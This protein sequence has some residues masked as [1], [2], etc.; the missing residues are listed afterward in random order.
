MRCRWT[1]TS[2]WS[3]QK[4]FLVLQSIL[5]VTLRLYCRAAM[6]WIL[7]KHSTRIPLV[8]HQLC[9][10][11]CILMKFLNHVNLSFHAMFDCGS[12]SSFQEINSFPW[13]QMLVMSK[14]CTFHKKEYLLLSCVASFEDW[15]GIFRTQTFT[16]CKNGPDFND[17]SDSL[18]V[19]Q[20]ISSSATMNLTVCR[21]KKQGNCSLS[22]LSVLTSLDS[23]DFNSW[24]DHF[25]SA[26]HSE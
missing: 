9:P 15:S 8:H 16:L 26:F 20:S 13:I 3:V 1:S 10:R 25:S 17:M 19:L 22:S 18:A 23:S 14:T 21:A 7:G 11:L 24:E 4:I 5:T 2:W 6:W 12:R